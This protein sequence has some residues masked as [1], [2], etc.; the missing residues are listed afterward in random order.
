MRWRRAAGRRSI[1]GRF[2]A[3]IVTG[4]PNSEAFGPLR[5][6]RRADPLKEWPAGPHLRIRAQAELSTGREATDSDESEGLVLRMTG[7]SRMLP[8]TPFSKGV[9]RPR[10]EIS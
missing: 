6:Y 9:T 10:L 2:R 4:K 5:P 8:E 1:L 7:R 3:V